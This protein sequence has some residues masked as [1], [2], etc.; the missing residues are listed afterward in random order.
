MGCSLKSLTP[1]GFTLAEK[2]PEKVPRSLMANRSLMLALVDLTPTCAH[3]SGVNL[4]VWKY[5]A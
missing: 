4:S 5:H 3:K 2:F 1:V